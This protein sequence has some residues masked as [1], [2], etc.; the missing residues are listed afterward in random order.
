MK[1]KFIASVLITLII[2]CLVGC[3]S[4]DEVINENSSNKNTNIKQIQNSKEENTNNDIKLK[5]E[6]S[7]KNLDADKDSN[8]LKTE[9][10]DI[11]HNT[12]IEKANMNEGRDCHQ[13]VVLDGKIYAISGVGTPTLEEY[14]PESDTWTTKASMKEERCYFCAVTLNGKIYVMGGHKYPSSKATVEEY[15]PKTNTW[16]SKAN[17]N[18]GRSFFD[19]TVIDNK[20]YVI[21]GIDDGK[22]LS[23]EEYNP[24]TDEWTNKASLDE[25]ISGLIG[26][27]QIAVINGKIYAVGDSGKDISKLREYD[28]KTNTWTTKAS[29]YE[30]RGANPQTV[31]VNGKIYII[32]SCCD[33]TNNEYFFKVEEYDP[34]TNTWT[35][36]T[37]TKK[38]TMGFKAVVLNNKIYTL[39]G[40]LYIEGNITA[41]LLEEYDPETNTWT[42]KACMNKKH[43]YSPTTAVLNGKIYIIGGGK[44]IVGTPDI[45]DLS[46]VEE[47][48]P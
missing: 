25:N 47:Y 36:K 11:V 27:C 35:T 19:S 8:N 29:L 38:S 45:E 46:T 16:T 4:T 41:K 7:E 44:R 28:P 14:D 48:T 10:C 23:I 15:D 43:A 6:I 2:S 12:W 37:S 32:D 24:K 40:E 30:E 1:R 34:K 26:N 3:N 13:T 18:K 9:E 31:V 33:K 20:I 22:Y 21:G 17:M 42:D 5:E 39:V